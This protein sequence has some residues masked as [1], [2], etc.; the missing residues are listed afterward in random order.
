LK[1]LGSAVSKR[2][3]H[4]MLSHQKELRAFGEME[5]NGLPR[6]QASLDKREEAVEDLEKFVQ[7][8]ANEFNLD[9]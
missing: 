3:L 8:L 6:L 1:Q 2:D 9:R 4:G 7:D 5:A